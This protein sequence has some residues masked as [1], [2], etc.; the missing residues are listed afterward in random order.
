[1]YQHPII[2]LL[3]SIIL[4]IYITKQSFV[5]HKILKRR[6][7]LAFLLAFSSA[8]LLVFYPE[9]SDS[10]SWKN[11]VDWIL[12]GLDVVIGLVLIFSTE[13]STSKS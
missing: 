8:L 12:I 3:L 10:E 2:P 6:L 11:T 1:M 9:I 7:L 4:L 5:E 13:M